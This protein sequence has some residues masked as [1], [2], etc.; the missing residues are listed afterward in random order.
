METTDTIA[1]LITDKAILCPLT[2]RLISKN[3]KIEI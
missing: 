2:S 1:E 3:V